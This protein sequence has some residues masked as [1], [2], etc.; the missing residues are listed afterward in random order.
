MS[1]SIP[2]RKK[3]SPEDAEFLPEKLNTALSL[4][5]SEMLDA[6]SALVHMGAIGDI[7]VDAPD[8]L[9]DGTNFHSTVW[10]C[11]FGEA[12]GYSVKK[13]VNFD[14]ELANGTSLIDPENTEILTWFKLF[15]SVQ[16]QERFNG[17]SRKRP[18]YELLKFN[19]GL[20]TIDHVLLND[21]AHFDIGNNGL[22]M[23]SVSSIR[24]FL[25]QNIATPVSDYLYEYPARLT[26]WFK[27]K[28]A[29]VTD[30]D[31]IEAIRKFPL[32]ENLPPLEDRVLDFNDA[33][34]IRV[35][36]IIALNGWY[37][38]Y[39][40]GKRFN[41]RVFITLEYKNT[42]HGPALMPRVIPE[43]NLE[44]SLAREFA[45]VPVTAEPAP[46]LTL[47]HLRRYVTTIQKIPIVEACYGVKGISTN[48]F[49]KIDAAQIFELSEKKYLGRF[50]TVPYSVLMYMLG[51]SFQ[52]FI[53]NCHAIFD[54]VL[55]L[56]LAVNDHVFISG[57][58]MRQVEDVFSRIVLPDNLKTM[59]VS[60]WCLELHSENFQGFY[61]DV[62][63]NK[64]LLYCYQVLMG[65]FLIIIGSLAARRQS[66]I[67]ELHPTKCLEPAADP[68]LPVNASLNYCLIYSARKTGNRTHHRTLSV[69]IT[70]PM[71]KFIWD[72]MEFRRKCEVHKFI[73]VK[74]H[75]L[76]WIDQRKVKPVPIKVW[77]YNQAFDI[78]CDYFE[79]Q[80]VNI[81]GVEKRYYLRQ[82]QLR[83]FIA[84]AFYHSS[85]GNIEA[86]RHLLGHSDVEHVYTYITESTPGAVLDS[87]KAEV[88]VD[89]MFAGE[90]SI[91]GLDFLKQKIIAKYSASDFVAR[92]LKEI[93]KSYEPL[94]KKGLR[95]SNVSLAELVDQQT[96]LNEVIKMLESHE[97]DLTPDFFVV[98]AKDGSQENRFNLVLKLAE[99]PHAR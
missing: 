51:N 25:L 83:R 52:Y 13:L 76:L 99:V 56:M 74:D 85:G 45:G 20:H 53:G 42:L 33:D 14:V 38:L 61:E 34:L 80:T 84:L 8:W 11:Y 65:T 75:L 64:Y 30:Q 82:H 36:T 90:D 44:D 77:S 73:S 37:D 93:E 4:P 17:G 26:A 39:P 98:T 50:V 27:S 57:S 69:G 88:I 79:S 91:E 3:S 7:S 55:A 23:V 47:D 78:A 49:E 41:P 94:V 96:C 43:L 29:E 40:G 59:G 9:I 46:G 95:K 31:V 70:L 1:D 67:I 5:F 24:S 54:A 62:R 89:C 71:A 21:R 19:R 97:I 66:E 81:H 16:V 18:T 87:A 48:G 63:S 32:I 86:L 2:D 58:K 72:V 6:V 60:R 28:L 10:S 68:Y 35:R 15:L 12:N 92:S 22:G